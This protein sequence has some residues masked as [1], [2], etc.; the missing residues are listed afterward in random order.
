MNKVASAW[1]HSFDTLLDAYQQIG[2]NIPLFERY[3]ELF[4]D[5][6]HM[7]NALAT[8]YEDILE[9]HRKAL[10]IFSKRSKLTTQQSYAIKMTCPWSLETVI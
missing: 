9:F 3:R 8:I 1:S 4:R 10:R 5:H 2:E 6:P 7:R